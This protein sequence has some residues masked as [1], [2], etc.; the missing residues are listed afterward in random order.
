MNNA[1]NYDVFK[2]VS[3]FYKACRDL[4][5]QRP[6]PNYL[7]LVADRWFPLLEERDLKRGEQY[8]GMNGLFIE[9][10]PSIGQ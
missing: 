2:S 9:I 1:Q 10:Q 4:T 5:P 7:P 3:D 6:H 8:S